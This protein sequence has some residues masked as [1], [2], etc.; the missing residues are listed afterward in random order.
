MMPC[1]VLHEQVKGCVELLMEL[2]SLEEVRRRQKSD[3][4]IKSWGQKQHLVE[5]VTRFLPC[6]NRSVMMQLLTELGMNS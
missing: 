6:A 1:H 4:A 5:R 3:I 2:V